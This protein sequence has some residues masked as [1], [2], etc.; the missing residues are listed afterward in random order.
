MLDPPD[1]IAE[2]YE[3][4]PCGLVLTSSAGDVLAVNATLLTLLGRARGEV[5]GLAFSQLMNVPGRIY[6]ETHIAPLLHMQGYVSE[7]AV[8]LLRA[9]GVAIP[10]F[11]SA[12]QARAGATE[13]SVTIRMALFHAIDRRKYERELLLARRMADQGLK[14]KSDFLAVFAHEIRNGLNGVQLGAALL[15]RMEL[16]GEAPRALATLRSSLHR[17]VDLLQN[18]LDLSAV[19]AGKVELHHGRFDLRD[20][21]GG[22]VRTLEPVAQ[23]KG[24]AIELAIGSDCPD[25]LVGDAVKI[26]QVIGNLAGNA[27]KFTERGKV[28]LHAELVGRE[29]KTA[30]I[31][32]RVQDT[33]IGIAP[34]RIARIWDEFGQGGPEIREHYGGSG[35][36]LAISRRIVELYGSRIHVAS[37]PGTG[38][39]FWFD[40]ALPVAGAMESAAQ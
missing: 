37:E 5:L 23:H 22:V 35:L 2:L 14:A 38:T 19:E 36:G 34:D 4:A 12:T 40:L 11:V 9:D 1:A 17:V 24:V 13:P 18:M 28:S 8:E 21:L 10:F 30:T 25:Q 16:P 27:V 15:E 6:Y 31:R 32:F 33:G 7:V 26:G 3:H 20:L 29:A 39:Q